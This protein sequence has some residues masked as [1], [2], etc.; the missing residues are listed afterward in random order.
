MATSGTY[1]TEVPLKGS[2]EKYYK[3]WKNENH[4][5]PDAIGHHIQNVTV[6][7]GEHDSHGSIRSW[8]Y[9]WG[10]QLLILSLYISIYYLTLYISIH[11]IMVYV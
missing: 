4:V 10:I 7:E 11:N 1:V 3:R 5:F 6:H 8:N 2:A 9:T